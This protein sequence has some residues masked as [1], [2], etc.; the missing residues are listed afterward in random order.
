MTRRLCDRYD[1]ATVALHES[2]SRRDIEKDA[3]F[4]GPRA[5][6]P[7]SA[8]QRRK[9]R[10]QRRPLR[11]SQAMCSL[12]KSSL[13]TGRKC[14]ALVL[15]RHAEATH[16][17]QPQRRALPARRQRV[18]ANSVH[19]V[20]WCKASEETSATP[21]RFVFAPFVSVMKDAS[22]SKPQ[23]LLYVKPPQCRIPLAREPSALGPRR[24]PPTPPNHPAARCFKY[25][26]VLWPTSLSRLSRSLLHRPCAPNSGGSA[27]ASRALHPSRHTLSSLSER[28]NWAGSLRV[29][30]SVR[31]LNFGL[32]VN[33]DARIPCTSHYITRVGKSVNRVLRSRR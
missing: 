24:L 12:Q 29:R 20:C 4:G 26:S 11:S 32:G 21:R 16:K 25:N 18:C 22:D 19:S 23:E 9:R 6:R 8:S 33:H 13:T 27:R 3:H 2:Q 15:G 17:R 1:S 28:Q 5:H 14:A 30:G 7:S 31:A 10:T